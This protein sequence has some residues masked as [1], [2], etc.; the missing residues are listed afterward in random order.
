MDPAY[1]VA[2]GSLKARAFQLDTVANN[3]ANS[4]TVGYKAERNFFDIFNKAKDQGRGLPLSPW[5]NDGVVYAQRGMDFSQGALRH[6]ER[7]F[8][9]AIEG[10]AFFT[11]ESQDGPKVTRDG[12]FTLAADGQLVTLD[13]L[14]VLG[15]NGPITINPANGHLTV[16]GDGSIYQAGA[17]IDQL[18]LKAYE[19][20]RPF[21]RLGNGRFDA[22]L[23]QEAPV[24]GSV[25]QGYLEQSSV[26]LASQMVEMIRLNRLFEIS[27]KVASTITNDLD[28]KSLT[29]G[30][31]Q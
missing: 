8:D 30:A 2:A 3:I 7:M 6:T 29:I 19:D 11:V 27:Q 16:T 20:T 31:G 25:V 14:P 1:Y 24:E 4:T 13:G 22:S 28:A 12:R 17:Y 10:N 5:V 21:T 9:F 23:A 18:D 26:D 15:T